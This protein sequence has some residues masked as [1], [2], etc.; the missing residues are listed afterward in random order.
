[1]DYEQKTNLEKALFS[2]TWNKKISKAVVIAVEEGKR[3]P[4]FN[5]KPS[6]LMLAVAK[7]KFKKIN[8]E[9]KPSENIGE[10]EGE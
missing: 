3:R 1:M 5:K 8:L 10:G 9:S 4:V 2:Q 7:E 6:P